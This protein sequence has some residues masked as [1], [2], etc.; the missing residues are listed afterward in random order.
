[1]RT[2]SLPEVL[3]KRLG[4]GI[5]L[6][7]AYLQGSKGLKQVG[8]WTL[9][10]SLLLNLSLLLCCAVSQQPCTKPMLIQTNQS[11]WLLL[12]AK[13]LDWCVFLGHFLLLSHRDDHGRNFN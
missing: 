2:S 3:P 11:S 9:E 7:N 6:T 13:E 12:L 4:E 8:L 1:M 5:Y 10:T